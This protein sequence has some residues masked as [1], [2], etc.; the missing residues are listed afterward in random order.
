[1]RIPGFIRRNWKLKVLC[2]FIAFV[3]WVGVV[4]AGNP[5][6]TRLVSLAVPQ[7]AANVP[8]GY[9]LVHSVNNVLVRVGGDQN[10]LNTLNPTVF[11]VNVDWAA[12]N[13][14]G[15]YSIPM[16][17]TSTDPNIEI[18]DRPTSVQVDL[19]AFTS[20]SIPV[21]ITITNPPPAGYDIVSQQASPSTVVVDG[22]AHELANIQ[23]RA[24]VNL[25]NQ[26]ANFQEQVPVLV[27]GNNNQ[28]LNNVSAKPSDV[29]I[30]I[31]ITAVVTT[32]TVAIAPRIVGNPSQGHY[33]IGI[34]VTPFSV[35]AT[36][37]Q[38]LL[39]SFLNLSTVAI[40]LGGITGDFTQTVDII[41][42]AGITLSVKQVSVEIEMGAVPTPPPSP[43]PAPTPTPTSGT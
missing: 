23:A 7:S 33:L 15:T 14:A 16:T 12:V 32:R 20:R 38:D 1:M 10:T 19:D 36:G 5:P 3:T 41:A 17:I 42:P 29:S 39:N 30:S 11:T 28:R 6:E 9:V 34:I 21:T 8:S 35:V 26:K 25:S 22:P 4:Y 37:P 31:S 43:T 24:S 40:P 27:Y 13:R 18:I 2:F